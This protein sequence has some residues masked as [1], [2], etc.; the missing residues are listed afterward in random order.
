VKI[1]IAV[2]LIALCLASAVQAEPTGGRVTIVSL[3]P[4]INGAI[5][6]DVSSSE[7]CGTSVFSIIATEVNGKEMYAAALTALASGKQ[8]RLEVPTAVGC[9]GWGSRLSSIY[10]FN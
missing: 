9:T 8:V 1:L 4:H 7:F 6:V 3:R 2:L 5:Y 10:L